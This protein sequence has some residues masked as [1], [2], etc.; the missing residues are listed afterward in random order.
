M[1]FVSG[2]QESS[3]IQC[4][5][6]ISSPIRLNVD[7]FAPSPALL[8][9]LKHE[10]SCGV[11]LNVKGTNSFLSRSLRSESPHVNIH[12][13]CGDKKITHYPKKSPQD[14]FYLCLLTF[15]ASTSTKWNRKVNEV[16][17]VSFS[18]PCSCSLFICRFLWGFY[19][20]SG[21]QMILSHDWSISI[22]SREESRWRE[23]SLLPPHLGFTL[24][25]NWLH[26]SGQHQ[27]YIHTVNWGT[28]SIIFC[29]RNERYIFQLW[30][31]SIHFEHRLNM[32]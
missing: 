13:A 21:M 28:T 12:C 25:S 5:I 16:I 24:L 1:E 2:S 18:F 9:P 26:H 15:T 7:F 29:L 3:S 11:C 32:V 17:D 27:L 23:W 20:N 6:S 19:G 22:H 30:E 14:V 8:L 10:I 4:C 31:M